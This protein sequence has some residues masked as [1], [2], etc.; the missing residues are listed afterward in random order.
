[1]LLYSDLLRE[2]LFPNFNCLVKGTRDE[3]ILR[4]VVDWNVFYLRY[5]SEMQIAIKGFLLYCIKENLNVVN[6]SF[7]S[8][9]KQLR[10]I[11]L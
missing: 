1:M 3:K 7:G 5:W 10:L 2:I 11:G 4:A 8:V 6:S 9:N